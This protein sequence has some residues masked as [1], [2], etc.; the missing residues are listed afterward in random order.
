MEDAART[1]NK[2]LR[3][4]DPQLG[5]QKFLE[6]NI[7]VNKVKTSTRITPGHTTLMENQRH[8]KPEE[9]TTQH[10]KTNR[11]YEAS[12]CLYRGINLMRII[13][14]LQL[15]HTETGNTICTELKLFN[16]YHPRK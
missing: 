13:T 9:M 2:K 14:R 6:D 5:L 16:L 3:G 15:N 7:Q 4:I 1:R 10:L 8:M 11:T 12:I